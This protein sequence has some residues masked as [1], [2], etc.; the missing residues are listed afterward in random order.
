M[1]KVIQ[2][3][4][5]HSRCA[6]D[7]L[8]IFL[9][10]EDIDIAL[11]QEPWV[12]ASK[13]RGLNHRDYNLYYKHVVDDKGKPRSCILM[14]K[15]LNAL[16]CTNFSY[17]DITVIKVDQSDGKE[18]YISSVYLPHGEP[19]PTTKLQELV[20]ATANKLLVGC[21]ANARHTLWGSSE[22]NER[23]ESLFDYIL[24]TNLT[25]C[26]RGST[27][28][29][30][31]PSSE[32]FP[33]WE[34]VIDITLISRNENL[35]VENWRV[36]E[37]KSFS[38]HSWILFTINIK[39]EVPKPYRNPKS[40]NWSKFRSVLK[41]RLPDLSSQEDIKTITELETA[42][43]KYTKAMQVSFKVSCPIKRSKRSFPRGGTIT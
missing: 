40:T 20:T 13:I 5:K 2:V 42:T 26:N 6:S 23:G 43:D 37:K 35:K 22:I 39:P 11:I 14:K 16:L 30:T 12:N 21:D 36:S 1:M 3:N 25:V 4:L 38:D 33:G 9:S 18:L 24:D 27:P 19:A 31:F 34:D 7:N 17:E 41:Q 15:H 10:E 8:M 32:N 29:F 28:T